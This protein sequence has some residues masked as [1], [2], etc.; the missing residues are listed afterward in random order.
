MKGYSFEATVV[1]T[2]KC[3]Y[4][5]YRGPWEAETWVRERML[6]VIAR[7][8]A[9]DPADVR[10][11]NMV[12]GDPDDRLVTG[13]SLAGVSSRQSFER[14]LEL[15][16]YDRF[17][18]EQAE[19]RAAGRYRGMGFATFVEAAP[20]PAEMRAG[21][22]G[23][24]R[25]RV[26]VEPDGHLLV[27]T[28]QAPHGQ[29][30][31]TTLAQIAA[32]EMGVPFEQV[33]VVHG[34]TRLTPFSLIGTGGSRSATWASGAVL[35]NTRKVREKVLAIAAE[36]LEISP[37]DLDIADGTI[38][39][40]GVPEKSLPLADIARQVYLAP[41]TLPAGTDGTL[42]ASEIYTGAG[43]G[44]SGWSGGTHLCEVDVD[45]ETGAVEIV[46]WIAVEDCGRIINPAVVD[47]Q[48]RGGVAQGIGGVLYEHSAYDPVGQPLATT[49]MDY[50]VPT[51]V[52]IPKIQ[53][54]HLE[55]EPLGEV[56]FRGVGEA[57]AVVSPA[58]LT[59]AI[60]DALAPLGV[61]VTDQHLPPSRILELLGVT[62]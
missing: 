27:I 38:V 61:R 47:G 8:L 34:D 50:L 35:Y 29:S 17:R 40:R 11:K 42:E 7:E 13:P 16:G 55:T 53:I 60:E 19:G 51:A 1:A 45:V 59:N 39:P 52:E 31:E 18:S 21:P 3:S 9:I 14:A 30:H 4:V 26:R 44:G 25:A 33:R 6:D 57:G 37:E 54:E 12:A 24:E 36:V 5:A 56:D 48:I 28:A 41:N 49:F 46:R 32:D 20:G 2:N 10:R 43:I 15:A 58:A 23:H 62:A 22:F